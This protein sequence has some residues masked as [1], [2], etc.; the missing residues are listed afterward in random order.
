MAF[1]HLRREKDWFVGSVIDLFI[2]HYLK[3]ELL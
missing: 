2:F 3:T 1:N